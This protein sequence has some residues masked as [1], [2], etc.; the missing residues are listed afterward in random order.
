M[1]LTIDDFGRLL[2]AKRGSRG[3]RAAALDAGVSAAT[4]SRV[5]NGNMPDLKTFASLCKWLSRDPREFL[6]MESDQIVE[7]PRAVVHFKKKRTVKVE[8]AKALGELILAAQRAILAA[9]DMAGR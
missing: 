9:E 3:I 6:G 8:T 7:R 4:F 2:A 5:E 1:G